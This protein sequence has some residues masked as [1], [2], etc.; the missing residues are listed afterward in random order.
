MLATWCEELIHLQR[1]WC[2]ERLKAGGEGDN[3]GWDGWMASPTCWTWVWVSSRSWWW[4]GR[5]DVLQSMGLQRVGHDWATELNWIG[6]PP[7]YCG[8]SSLFTHAQTL[9]RPVLCDPMDRSPLGSSV[10]G[11][12]QARVLEWVAMLSSGIF[13]T[14]GSSSD[15]LSLL[16]WQGVSLPLPTPG[17]PLING[18]LS[19]KSINKIIWFCYF[20]VMLLFPL[21]V[22]QNIDIVIEF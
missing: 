1:P 12:L 10:H 6:P 11:L 22:G 19:L 16:N 14:Q 3:R 15:L 9:S 4:T 8:Q 13:L 20:Q 18:N 5:P 21:W 7:S 17:K 2:W